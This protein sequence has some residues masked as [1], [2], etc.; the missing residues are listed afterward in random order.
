MNLP[1]IVG[2]NIAERRKF[3]GLSQK[4][5][6]ARLCI[7]QDA[8]ALMEKGKIAPQISC[9]PDIA[10]LLRCT[11]PS[12]FRHHDAPMQ[13][14]AATIANILTTISDDEQKDVV[15]IVEEIARAMNLRKG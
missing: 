4:E 2:K 8:M 13:E 6:A 12:L 14:R 9:L 10:S 5:L 11:V 3:L 15:N 1:E 7:T